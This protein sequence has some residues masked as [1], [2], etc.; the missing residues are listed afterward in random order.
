MD[1][2]SEGNTFTNKLDLSAFLN[3][4]SMINGE[5]TA[6]NNTILRRCKGMLN[7]T[8]SGVSSSSIIT[9]EEEK[10]SMTDSRENVAERYSWLVKVRDADGRLP[11]MTKNFYNWESL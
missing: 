7:N 5:P 1:S 4:D 10:A 11:G 6:P 3:D 8:S 2:D 9:N